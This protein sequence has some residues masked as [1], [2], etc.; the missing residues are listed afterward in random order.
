MT[1]YTVTGLQFPS[2]QRIS[3][4][5]DEFATE[6]RHWD[7]HAISIAVDARLV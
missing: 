4:L 5:S 2:D 7:V 6:L 1:L 3:I